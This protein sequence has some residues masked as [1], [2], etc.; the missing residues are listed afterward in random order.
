[1]RSLPAP[2]GRTR[3]LLAAALL[4]LPALGFVRWWAAPTEQGTD[5]MWSSLVAG[6]FLL[7]FL[8]LTEM[9]GQ[10][11]PNAER[12]RYGYLEVLIGTDGY[13]ST[14][15]AVV[16]LWTLLFAAALV[17]LSGTVWFGGLSAEEAFGE[18]WNSYL[19]LLGGPFASAV[20]AKGITLSRP[21]AQSGN[22][23]SAASTGA[24]STAA[25]AP[26]GTTGANATVGPAG[27]SPSLADLGRSSS[28]DSSLADTQYVVFSLVAMIYFLGAFLRNLATYGA[29]E[30][31]S[32]SIELPEIPSALLGLT[33]LAALTYVG[34]KVVDRS[35]LRLVSILPSPVAAGGT[36]EISVVNASQTL[37]QG[38]VTIMF[39]TDD[40]APV[41]TLAPLAA[42]TR[43]GAVTTLQTTVPPTA[44]GYRVVVVTP[45]GSTTPYGITVG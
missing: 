35:G 30:A 4:A 3:A 38:T 36:V 43:D 27:G 42:P 20:L 1:V 28:G 2:V 7:L 10:S 17:M 32:G 12:R 33:S 18:E 26:A 16:W 9:V 23:S 24:L 39:T 29:G 5:L 37:T 31:T 41:A 22:I 11:N 6:L 40:G 34:A 13:A 19:L 15:K 14:S 45:E 21:Q 44:G 25:V 8:A